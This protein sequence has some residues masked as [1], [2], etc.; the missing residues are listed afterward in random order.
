MT[1][2]ETALDTHRSAPN[3]PAQRGAFDPTVSHRALGA[4]AHDPIERV[5]GTPAR[6]NV[7][8]SSPFA[9]WRPGRSAVTSDWLA[10]DMCLK[11]PDP[12][13]GSQRHGLP[14]G[15]SAHRAEG[16]EAGGRVDRDLRRGT[17]RPRVR[18]IPREV[19]PI[20]RHRRS[21][22]PYATHWQA[23]SHET[24]KPIL[25]WRARPMIATIS[26]QVVADLMTIDPIT[27]AVDAPIEEA[28]RLMRTYRVSGLPVI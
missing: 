27:V 14:V 8:G 19:G 2:V 25:P 17:R 4:E 15:W 7:H 16:T 3:W 1:A 28:E 10:T 21:I 20:G 26:R 6:I 13:P 5:R 12:P 11:E 22:R 18:R 24:N 23:G 9:L